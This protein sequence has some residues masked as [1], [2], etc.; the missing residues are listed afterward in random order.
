[1]K[2]I[3]SQNKQIRI[4]AWSF[5]ISLTLM[6]LRLFQIQVIQ[7][8]DYAKRALP[9]QTVTVSLEEQRGEIT[10]RNGIPFTQV[11]E[12]HELIIF[13]NSIGFNDY[14]YEIIEEM[15]GKSKEH[16][17]GKDITYYTESITNPDP[18]WIKAI[19][20]GVFPGVL[21]QKSNM[22][23]GDS[24]L[25]RHVIGY[26]RKSD[27]VPLSGIEKVFEK[28]LHTG[29]A[30]QVHAVADA[31]DHIIPGLGYTLTEPDTKPYNVRLTLDY[32]IQEILEKA[33]DKYPD[34]R[35]G[36]LVVDVQSGDILALAS[37][38]QFKQ[39]DPAAAMND[40]EE[41]S[42]L[43]I[44]FEQYPLGSVFKIIVA[45]AALESGKYT[46]DTVFNCTGGI[47]V[48]NNFF[49]CYSST[50]GLGNIT[51]RNAF[52]HSC[53]DTFIKVAMDIG[54]D[55]IIQTAEKFGLGKS[56][57]IEL[58]NAP[59]ILMSRQHYTGPGIANLSIGQGETMVTPLQI[60]DLLTTILNDGQ[61]KEL[62]LV[63]GLT[64]SQ[65]ELVEVGKSGSNT[66]RNDN[67]K[68]ITQKTARQLAAWMADVTEYGTAKGARDPQIGGTA[69]KTGTPQVSGDPHSKEY[70]WFAGYFPQDSPKYV[71]VIL[72]REEGG[73][74]SVA[75]PLFHDIA[76]NIWLNI[77]Q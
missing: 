24:S 8:S 44:P 9:Q 58:P 17:S 2:E 28:H 10:D 21:Y 26:L 59:G 70:G 54:G 22:R 36:G 40:S 48:G 11:G 3:S 63:A 19:E 31:K 62:R 69:G 66:T 15:T 61:R 30:K 5:T 39:Y 18:S 29:S 46:E 67:N 52:A 72:S 20:D 13:P 74:D 25:A 51:L 45:A 73:A 4:L 41:A 43:A 27:G 35:H 38:P 75:V 16:F 32:K 71:I 76:R 6:V 37:R 56:L 53:N 34:R 77:V 65:G 7:G 64:N 1:M 12:I 49:P 33:L 47:Q 14:A 42:F 68:V 55:A 60:A 57:D 23:Y 50:G